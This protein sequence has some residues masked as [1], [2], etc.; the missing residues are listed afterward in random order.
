ML[1]LSTAARYGTRL[2]IEVARN[3][4]GSRVPVREMAR[5]TGVSEKYLGNLVASLRKA[6]L[7]ASVRGAGGGYLLA[8]PPESIRLLDII[9]AMDGP[10]VAVEC[11]AEPRSC[12]RSI[13]CPTRETWRRLREVVVD[14]LASRTIADLAGSRPADD[15]RI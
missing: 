13:D 11:L 12:P 7:L 9:E 4:A 2:M 15:Y 14:F 8:R 3:P 6:G 1:K 10:V 5:R